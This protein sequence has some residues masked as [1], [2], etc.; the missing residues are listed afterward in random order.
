ASTPIASSRFQVPRGSYVAAWNLQLGTRS[1]GEAVAEPAHRLDQARAAWLGLD[2]LAQPADVD[3]HRA[4]VAGRAVA[5]DALQ[6]VVA[7]EGA[8]R[9]L[10]QEDQQV[11]LLGP[12][13]EHLAAAARLVALQVYLDLAEAQHGGPVSRLGVAQH[14]HAA[15][16]GAHAG[17]QLAQ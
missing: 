3:V 6:Q 13:R 9:V 1:I 7:R 15:Q 12:E 4:R 16:V 10:G 17:Y 5:P 8:A 14:L 2:L 11:V